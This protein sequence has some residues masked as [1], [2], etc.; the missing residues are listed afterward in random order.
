MGFT[1]LEKNAP[2]EN[3]I[4]FWTRLK[5]V[6]IPSY[7]DFRNNTI[8]PWIKAVWNF[9]CEPLGEN[10]TCVSTE[11]RVHCV[12]PMT[13]ITFGLYWLMIKPFSGLIR[14]KMLTI[15]KHEAEKRA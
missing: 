7:E 4:G 15:I 11:T 1:P 2:Y 6:H 9:K 3:L 5:I 14:K 12:A 8:S 10:K 13:R